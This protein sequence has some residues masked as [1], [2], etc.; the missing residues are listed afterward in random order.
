[1][2]PK[3]NAGR[4]GLAYRYHILTHYHHVSHIELLP[5]L[6]TRSWTLNNDPS[7]I[8]LNSL[9]KNTHR[10]LLSH[11]LTDAEFPS[12]TQH[13]PS[14]EEP[15]VFGQRK[16]TYLYTERKTRI[17]PNTCLANT[18]PKARVFRLPGIP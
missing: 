10:L 8:C 15:I 14:S 18:S 4:G 17:T 9:S 16:A 1:M 12:Y 11:N 7:N 2:T 6:P 3:L 5:T 13:S